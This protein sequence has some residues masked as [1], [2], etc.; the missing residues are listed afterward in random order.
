MFRSVTYRGSFIALVLLM[1]AS[2]SWEQTTKKLKVYISVDMEGIAGVVT[3]D[4]LD[5]SGFEY[6]RFRRFMTAEALAAVNAA[7]EGG[8]TEVVV[9][10]SHGRSRNILIVKCSKKVIIVVFGPGNAEMMVGLDKDS[11]AGM[12]IGYHASK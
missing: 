2:A 1:A 4:Q 7:K 8:A 6:E 12:F 5:P 10:D 11:K 3:L 9:S